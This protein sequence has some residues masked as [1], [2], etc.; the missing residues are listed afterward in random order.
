M[1]RMRTRTN[2][3]FYAERVRR[4]LASDQER[5]E[6]ITTDPDSLDL[7]V[8]NFFASLDTDDDREYLASL[9]RPLCGS[10]V[11]APVRMSMWTG[12]DAEPRLEPSSAYVAHLRS[13][14]GED[15]EI[16]A[17]LEPVEVPVRIEARNVLAL[18]D[19]VW[20]SSKRGNGGRD[21]LIELVDVGL[22]Q[23]ERLGKELAIAVIYRSGSRAAAEVSRR[24]NDLRSSQ[25]LRAEMPWL[26]SVPEV[27]FRELSW[28]QLATIWRN[29]R[30]NLRLAGEPVRGFLSHLE[31]IGLG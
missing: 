13:R 28:Q 21:R 3:L 5:Y 30:R 6:R 12:R 9:L 19:T 11:Q 7:L 17:F 4:L 15:A 10:D 23:A 31:A 2:P 1:L 14:V 8:W 22:V 25:V 16:G 29:E 24:M 27:R 18:V 20:D 26:D